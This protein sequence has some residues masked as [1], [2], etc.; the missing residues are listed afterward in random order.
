[1]KEVQKVRI[2]PNRVNR[3]FECILSRHNAEEVG[4]SYIVSAEVECPE[5]GN[6][7]TFQVV[8]PKLLEDNTFYHNGNLYVAV[9]F[10]HKP[11]MD[12]QQVNYKISLWING[13]NPLLDRGIGFKHKTHL[14][15]VTRTK[16]DFYTC[17]VS[18]SDRVKQFMLR[19]QDRAEF[20]ATVGS[21]SSGPYL[22]GEDLS[23]IDLL[24]SKIENNLI[25]NAPP[26]VNRSDFRVVSIPDILGEIYRIEIFRCLKNFPLNNVIN[27]ELLQHSIDSCIFSMPWTQL[28]YTDTKLGLYSLKSKIKLPVEQYQ[29]AIHFNDSWKNAICCVDTPQ[30]ADAGSILAICDGAKIENGK[31]IPG[32]HDLSGILRKAV[33]FPDLLDEKRQVIVAAT[34]KQST[35]L[36]KDKQNNETPF[37]FVEGTEHIPDIPGVLLETTLMDLTY[38]HEDGCIISESAAKRLYTERLHQQVISSPNSP[39]ELLVETGDSVGP[40]DYVAKVVSSS[41][42][43]KMVKCRINTRGTIK[44]IRQKKEIQS[45]ILVYHW[46]LH[47]LVEYPCVEGSKI[48]GLHSNKHTISK[49]WP[50]ERMPCYENGVPTELVISPMSIGNRLNPSLV[51]EL[52]LNVYCRE[53]SLRHGYRV[54]LPIDDEI[55]KE[56]TFS[57]VADM[58]K[59]IDL[60]A[61]CSYPLR[62]GKNS[63]TTDNWSLVGPLFIMRLA[64]HSPDKLRI[65]NKIPVEDGRQLRGH[66]PQRLGREELEIL[67]TVGTNGILKEIRENM[68]NSGN[69]D[70]MR[71]YLKVIGVYHNDDILPKKA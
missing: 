18:H 41:E 1:M 22:T 11:L 36:G 66:G 65:G 10:L 3:D 42:K 37:L 17:P 4:D 19:A 39:A 33:L 43:V 28:H 8:V 14:Q 67:W 30:S 64:H 58:L 34:T 52:M 9:P 61:T 48:A 15:V 12:R 6:R 24:V 55:Q 46:I 62:N 20:N 7:G 57:L 70:R 27:A 5:T 69:L 50:D 56:I 51:M 49:I 38:T 31:L 16:D 23:C 40:T 32:K 29:S 45:G 60:S 47:I 35:N 21:S 54:R 63:R 13:V 25:D 2:K 44:K 26:V 71:E 53:L 68:R 59:S